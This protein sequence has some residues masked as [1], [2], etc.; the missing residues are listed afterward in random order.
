MGCCGNKS[1]ETNSSHDNILQNFKQN[2]KEKKENNNLQN[3]K[4]NKENN[5]QNIKE[6]NDNNKLQNIKE[7]NNIQK[8]QK[9][10]DKK[11]NL[12]NEISSK[13]KINNNN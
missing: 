5:L 12:H 6:N 3:L 10:E 2:T 13:D 9:L 7:N 4:D 8:K 1:I 11:I